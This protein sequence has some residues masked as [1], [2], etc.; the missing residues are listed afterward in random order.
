MSESDQRTPLI[1]GR[2]AIF[3]RIA[4]GGMATVHFG[5]LVGEV[6]F[7]R[8]VAIKRLHAHF[9][10][11]HE[12][13]SMFIDEARIAA[14]VRHPNVVQTLD[15]GA[16]DG[17]LF[18]VMD[19]VVGEPLSR[20]F[21][22]ASA[23]GKLL[24]P[25]LVARIMVDVLHGL[26]AA[27]DA[28]NEAGEA[29]EIVHR[30][31]SPQNVLVD[32]DGISRVLDFGVAKAVGQ[33]HTTRKGELKG[34]IAYMAPE[35]LLGE[36]V[37]RR[38][39]VFAASIMLWELLVGHRL[40]GG[41]SEGEI[42]RKVL[43]VEVTPPSERAPSLSPAIDALVMRGLAREPSERYASAADMAEAIEACI[44]L[45]SPRAVGAWVREQ[46]AEGL[47]ERASVVAKIESGT[48][49][50]PT[51]DD[52]K[53]I[54]AETEAA[55]AAALSALLADPQER[56]TDLSDGSPPGS[57][58]TRLTYATPPTASSPRRLLTKVGVACIVIAS[59]VVAWRA[60]RPTH[61]TTASANDHA[62]AATEPSASAQTSAVSATE[63][64]AS[65]QPLAPA[66]P[67][68]SASHRVT[69]VAPRAPL[70]R[71][72]APVT[73]ASGNRRLYTRE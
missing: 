15:V 60:I 5:R 3:D 29:L 11:D 30:D 6:G 44:P 57:G 70:V 35:Q 4:A 67:S 55:R 56:V 46:A 41:S 38:T 21:R 36:D 43:E 42:V 26:H 24:D 51:P 64:S 65:A 28:K 37:T 25:G 39:D 2:Y 12:F 62:P 53:R 58:L 20:L 52:S 10:S 59:L 19:Y 1:V 71:G 72:S 73:S 54:A 13:V 22:G 47:A 33:V 63:A 7:T 16:I 68:A 32:V 17:E 45:M 40:F 18:V 61:A 49:V 23:S 66:Q 34:K 69:S 14:R 9:A 50:V 48:T 31:V 27:H 8:T